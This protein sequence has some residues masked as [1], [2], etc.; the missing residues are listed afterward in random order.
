MPSASDD[1][2]ESDEP[3]LSSLSSPPP[4]LPSTAA[5]ALSAVGKPAAISGLSFWNSWKDIG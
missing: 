1:E 5:I 4:P 3:S 2:R